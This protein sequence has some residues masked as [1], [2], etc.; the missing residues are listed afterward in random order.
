MNAPVF[1]AFAPGV[2]VSG[3]IVSAISSSSATSAAV[4]AP[5][6]WAIVLRQHRIVKRERQQV[7]AAGNCGAAE[8]RRHVANRIPAADR[9]RVLFVH[10]ALHGYRLPRL[11]SSTANAD[12]R[13]V[14][15][16]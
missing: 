7:I 13:A 5:A 12:A 14:K 15:A 10:D 2:E 16:M 1:A 11:S 8:Q 4:N 3:R 9:V 6:P